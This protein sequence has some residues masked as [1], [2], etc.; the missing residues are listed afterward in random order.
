MPM[1]TVC[2]GST[3][4]ENPPMRDSS[5]GSGPSSAA[6]GMPCTLPLV[7]VAGR[8]HVAVRVHPDQ[9]ERLA[10]RRPHESAVGRD[11]AGGQ[12][13]IAAEDDRECRPSRATA[14]EVL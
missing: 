5:A 3:F 8:V 2:S 14:S 6:S 13:V 12:A 1:R 4:G 11:R 9:A 7:D 10:R